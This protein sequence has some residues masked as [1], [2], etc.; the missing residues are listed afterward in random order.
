M[1]RTKSSIKANK[2]LFDAAVLAAERNYKI[3]KGD[4]IE[5]RVFDSKGEFLI[6][7]PKIPPVDFNNSNQQLLNQ[8]LNQNQNN[9]LQMQFMLNNASIAG[10]D[11]P[12]NSPHFLIQGD[13][14]ALLPM[15][16][17][18]YLENFTLNQ[19][20]S[21]LNI[22]YSNHYK[23]VFVRTRYNNKRVIVFKG[24]R[25]YVFPLRNEKISLIEV[26][27]AT[28]G[29]TRDLKTKNIRLIR[30]NLQD[31]DV[32]LINLRKM[33]EVILQNLTVEPN[34]IIYVEPN[35]FQGLTNVSPILSL[36]STGLTL[37]LLFRR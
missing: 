9:S 19:A 25:S 34:D 30:G 5:V 14:T 20:D 15:V 31:P 37:F 32:Y 10:T 1:F 35:A 22:Q 11:N 33:N 29:M 17:K 23:D 21:V 6:L 3:Q 18:V 28:G 26:L 27:A 24:D 12:L 13:G 2:P 16:G 8:G 7:P 36:I 4:Y